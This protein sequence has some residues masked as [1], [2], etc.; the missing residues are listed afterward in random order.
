MVQGMQKEKMQKRTKVHKSGDLT[1]LQEDLG[2]EV[3]DLLSGSGDEVDG[4]EV[5]GDE[6]DGDDDGDG[7]DDDE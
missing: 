1:G 7:D 3:T 5:D 2:T 6:V 4:D